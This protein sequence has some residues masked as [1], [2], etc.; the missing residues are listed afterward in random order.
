MVTL[1]DADCKNSVHEA[2]ILLTLVVA[3][4]ES[5]VHEAVILLTLVVADCENSVCEATELYVTC[6]L[7]QT[8]RIQSVMLPYCI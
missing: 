1:V 2:I 8:A 4:C 3:D 7:L 6:W 5:S